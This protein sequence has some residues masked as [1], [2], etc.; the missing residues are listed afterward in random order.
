[1]FP[2]VIIDF[3]MPRSTRVFLGNLAHEA[4]ER[5]VE[6]FFKGY[7]ILEEISLKQ[8]YGFVEFED[9]RD[10]DDAI[11]DLDGKTICGR[12]VQIE[13]AKGDR[14]AR[15][16]GD[17]Y[18]ARGPPPRRS[19]SD[20][21]RG[22]Q[23]WKEKYGLPKRTKYVVYVK[24]LSTRISWQTLK[25]YMR[26][27]GFDPTYADAHR[28][29]DH[30]GVLHFS[31]RDDME[32]AVEKFDGKEMNGRKIEMIIADEGSRSRSRSRSRSGSRGKSRS[33]SKSKS[34]SRSRDSKKSA[35]P[36][37]NADKSPQRKD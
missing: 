6:K 27:A 13:L 3:K 8:G 25:D 34:R 22:D 2:R 35:S 17:R 21:G 14:N 10:A 37:K 31:T 36:D 5:D 9:Y 30:E 19:F 7:G 33:K 28:E 32:K 16:E 29:R 11:N 1:M 4:T 12:R 15:R 18:A 24:N 20:R 23:A 26:D